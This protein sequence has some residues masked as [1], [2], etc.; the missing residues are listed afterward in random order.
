MHIY[1]SRLLALCS[2]CEAGL[3]TMYLARRQFAIVNDQQIILLVI[4]P[5]FLAIATGVVIA[6]WRDR[7]VKRVNTLV[8]DALCLCGLVSNT[9]QCMMRLM[10]TVTDHESSC[11]CHYIRSCS[12]GWPGF[13]YPRSRGALWKAS[14]ASL[15]VE[16]KQFAADVNSYE[17]S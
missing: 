3:V 12:V 17:S 5:V 2:Q 6:R 11:R 15:L 9:N 8:E 10:L 13:D 1:S 7:Q 4:P 16:S 14:E